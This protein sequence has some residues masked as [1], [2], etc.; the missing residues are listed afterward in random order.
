MTTTQR[1][2]VEHP[3]CCFCG[4]ATLATTRDH[5]P[6]KALFDG[7]HRPNSLVFPSCE[8]CQKLSK[9]H[10]L[11]AAMVARIFPNPTTKVQVRDVQKYIR[12]VGKA[13]PGLL[14][15]MRPAPDQQ[16]AFAQLRHQV[17]SAAGVLSFRGPLLNK[18]MEL[19]GVKLTCGLYYEHTRRIIGADEA[20]S[21]RVYTN[22]DDIQ[23]RLPDE[24][25]R[26][27]GERMT[28][29][30]GR[31]SVPDQFFYQHTIG[32]V[33]VPALIFSAFRR[34]FAI[35]G[36]LGG[37]VSNLPDGEGMPTYTPTPGGG[38]RQIR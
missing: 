33:Q 24:V 38:F 9:E 4:G 30:Q 2:L 3:A 12:R 25:L 7:K 35:L 23:G 28:L 21:V 8:H 6:A 26:L 1:F 20:I 22:V 32:R 5:V 10:E 14:E 13:V 16:A 18:S 15:Q 36:L 11:V 19:F 31:W 29:H 27:M 37:H 17:P 34:S